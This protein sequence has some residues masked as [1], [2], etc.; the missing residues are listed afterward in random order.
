MI[1][2]H[3]SL[4]IFSTTGKTWS[5]KGIQT[6]NR[7]RV[8]TKRFHS[9]LYLVIVTSR[10]GDRI[11]FT[12]N[13][14]FQLS[15][16][17]WRTRACTSGLQEVVYAGKHDFSSTTTSAQLGTIQNV[18]AVAT[19]GPSKPCHLC[20]PWHLQQV[21]LAFQVATLS[22][23]WTQFDGSKSVCSLRLRQPFEGQSSQEVKPQV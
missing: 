18:L 5:K 9:R 10:S 23:L 12:L 8:V 15:F 11:F 21:T 13:N 4:H 20:R 17:P 2:D 22:G 16:V 14:K 1:N 19:Y 6:L 7:R 3:S